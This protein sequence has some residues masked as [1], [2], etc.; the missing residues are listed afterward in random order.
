MTIVL[1][2]VAQVLHIA[3][4]IAAAPT[5]AGAMA[6]LDARLSGRTGPPSRA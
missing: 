2:L 3:L 5:L 4:M 6:W 1:S